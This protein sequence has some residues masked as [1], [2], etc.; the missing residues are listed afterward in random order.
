MISVID[1][2][3]IKGKCQIFTPNKIVSQMLDLAGYT[4]DVIGRTILE[5]SCGDGEFLVEIVSRYITSGISSN[6]TTEGICKGLEQ[7]IT[8][9]DIDESLVNTCKSRLDEIAQRYNLTSVKWNIQKR[10]FLEPDVMGQYDYIVG[11]PPYIAYSDLPECE[12]NALRSRFD[13][14]KKGKFDY[15]YAFIEKSY[16]MLSPTGKLVY[17]IPTNI[18]KNVFAD[19][20][21]TLIKNDLTSII[22]YPHDKVFKEVLVSP[23]IIVVNKGSNLPTLSYSIMRKE[24]KETHIVPKTTLSTKWIFDAV[25]RVGRRVGNHFKVS[26]TIATL[27]NDIFIL[28]DGC[29]RGDYYVFDNSSVETALLKKA[30]SPKSK[31]Y[32]KECNDYIIFPYYYN[33]AGELLRYS[34]DEM[35]QY[36]PYALAYLQN[37]KTKLS[38]RDADSSAKWYEYGRSQALQHIHQRKVIISSVISEDTKAYLLEAD[39]ISYAGLFITPTGDV[40]LE[41]LMTQLNSPAFREYA[42]SVGV[43][44]SG[45]SKRI[46]AKDIE[47][48]LF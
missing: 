25:D 26:N 31:R 9:Y 24:K 23:A 2:P 32:A 39:E 29:I 12:R 38:Q 6:M 22:D 7:D 33:D 14:C 30:T 47:N 11:N 1:D 45:S 46:S 41:E 17:I 37:H 13:S 4:G 44:V 3:R 43:S 40:T 10:S 19:T 34:E 20:L 15:S 27:C 21:R 8:A 42:S 48:F 35:K 18:F 28:K 16:K 36:F 5:N